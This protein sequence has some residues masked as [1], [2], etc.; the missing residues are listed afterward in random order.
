MIKASFVF[1]EKY[2]VSKIEAS[3]ALSLCFVFSQNLKTKICKIKLLRSD[4]DGTGSLFDTI[5]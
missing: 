5:G 2:F 3:F 1:A 4:T